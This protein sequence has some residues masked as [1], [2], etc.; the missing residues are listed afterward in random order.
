LTGYSGN[1]GESTP[2]QPCS[3]EVVR[4]LSGGMPVLSRRARTSF[5]RRNYVR[6]DKEDK[7][8]SLAGRKSVT[9]S[10]SSQG[11]DP[12]TSEVTI[13]GC[14][15]HDRNMLLKY[16][17][18]K[19]HSHERSF[20]NDHEG[21]ERM[22]QR[23]IEFAQQFG[24]NR[25]V[26]VYEASGQGFGLY[27]LLNQNGIEAYV[28][29]PT[30]LPKSQKVQ[31]NKTDAKDAQRLLEIARGFV[32]AG[33][34]MPIVWTPP[35]CLREDRELVRGRLEAA[36]AVT[37]V[38]LQIFSLLKRHGVITPEWFRKS[39]EWTR[40]FVKWLKEQAEKMRQVVTP[41]MLALIERFEV[42]Q[43]Q[44]TDFDRHLCHLAK[45]ERYCAAAAALLELPGVGVLTAMTFLTEM[46]DLTR[47][48]NRR[49]VAA[50]LGLCPSASESGQTDDRK[51]HITR[52]GPGRVRKVLCQAAWTRVRL[53]QATHDT[54]SRIQ[55]NKQGLG[56]KAIV[57]IMRKLGILMWHRAL[58]AGVCTDLETPPRAS[59]RWSTHPIE[60]AG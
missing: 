11:A 50:F 25:I 43:K 5:P 54:W 51:G 46:G 17:L 3:G 4:L 1:D 26:F 57:A 10:P 45:S 2:P 33:N 48:S 40:K 27:D 42:M 13:V 30:H 22:I 24:S 36:E 12:M 15:L 41:V 39:R 59:P 60:L 53:D 37:R 55:G 23:L 20:V 21:R 32:L 34:E 58:G 18:G 52:Q 7:V 44:V 38:K 47:F 8:S 29:S 35:R 16:A 31:K 19:G 6:V 9:F 28:L 49:Q 14:D 56:K